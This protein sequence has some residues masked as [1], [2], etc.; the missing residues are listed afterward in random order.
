MISPARTHDNRANSRAPVTN[1]FR[2]GSGLAAMVTV[3]GVCWFAAHV[4]ND[5]PTVATWVETDVSSSDPVRVF[6]GDFAPLGFSAALSP[7]LDFARL[8]TAEADRLLK[9]DE[10]VLGVAIGG[11]GR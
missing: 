11:E 1:T 2:I 10:P 9:P 3:G 6:D 8:S 7:V 4:A 5:Q